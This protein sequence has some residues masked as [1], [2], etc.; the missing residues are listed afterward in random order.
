MWIINPQKLQFEISPIFYILITIIT[1]LQAKDID[2]N[3]QFIYEYESDS[4]QYH[5]ENE[6]VH[7]FEV[8]IIGCYSKEKLNIQKTI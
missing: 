4:E 5:L 2:V 8:G 1:C 6:D 3:P 7:D